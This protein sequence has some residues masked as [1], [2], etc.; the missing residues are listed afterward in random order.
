MNQSKSSSPEIE[1]KSKS[2]SS[3]SSPQ[4]NENI[5]SSPINDEI[6]W[7]IISKY[8]DDNPKALVRHH[9]ESYNDFFQTGIFQIFKEKNPIVIN[10]VFDK[11]RNDFK[12]ECKMYFGGKDG[13]KIY[14]GKPVIYD[15]ENPHY[16]YPNEARL[17]NMTYS[18]TIHYD[19]DIEYIDYLEPGEQPYIIGGDECNQLYEG[20]DEECHKKVEDEVLKGGAPTN[21][22]EKGKAIRKKRLKSVEVDMS[23]SEAA[24]MKEN[25]ENSMIGT[26]I[27]KRTQ[28]LEKIYLGKFPIMV[29]SNFCILDGFP[30]EMIYS[31]GECRNDPGGYFIIDGKEK[32]VIPQEKFGD[33]IMYIRKSK[34]E[35]F[36]YSAEI[37]S[38]SENVTKPIRTLSI[39]MVAPSKG[40]T[41]KNIVVNVPNVR[42]PV[43]LFI[44]FRALGVISDK[45]IIT[46]C[47]LDLEKYKDLLDLFIPSVHDAGGIM[48][49]PAALSYIATLTKYGTIS[50]AMEILSDYFLPHIGELNYTEKA[51]FLGYMVFRLL[52]VSSGIEIP[53]DRDNYKFKR[54]ELVGSLLYDLFREYYTLQQKSVHLSFEKKLYYNLDKY[55]NSL[56]E[57]INHNYHEIF[58]E[59]I[60]E[61]GVK[62]AFK[63]DWGAS[64]HTKRIGAVQ[65]LNR[66]SFN[67][68]IS[69]LRKLNLPLDS[70]VKLVEPRVLHCSQWGFIDPIDTPDGANIGL[71]KT[72]A[73]ATY[74]SRGNSREPIIKWMF[75]NIELKKIEECSPPAY[76][77]SLTKV[78]VNGYWAGSVSDPIKSVQKMLLYRRNAL[79]PIYTSI[80][81]EIKL[82]TIFIYCDAGRVCRPIFYK[83]YSLSKHGNNAN[84]GNNLPSQATANWSSSTLRSG[85]SLKFSFENKEIIKHIAKDEFTWENLITGFNERKKGVKYDPNLIYSI[86]DLYESTSEK[87]KD[88][89]NPTLLDRFLKKKAIIDYIDPSESENA[90]ICMNI[91]DLCDF[92]KKKRFT[93]SSERNVEEDPVSVACRGKSKSGLYT[94]L[95]IHESLI[96]GVMCNQI[97]FP[98]HNPPTRNA[99]SCG[100]SKQAVSMYHTNYNVRTDKTAV[101]LHYGQTPLVKSRY[102]EYINHDENPYGINAVVA[103]MCYTG[104]N[105][106]DAILINEGSLKRGLFNTTYYTTYEAHEEKNTTASGNGSNKH[107]MNI[108]NNNMVVGTKAGYDYSSLDIYG[109]IKENTPVNDKTVLIGLATE[110]PAA[111]KYIDNSKTPK[112]GQ[113]GVVDKSFMTEGEE[114]ERIAKVRL[115]EIRIPNLGDKFASRAGQKGTVGMVVPEANMPFTREGIRPDIIINPHAIPTRMTIGQLVE[116]VFGKT[117][118]L[119]GGFSDCT[120]FVN[121]GSKLNMIGKHL[122]DVGFHSSGNEIL[123]NGMTGEQ[124]ETEIFI[125]PTYYMRLKH[126]VK[127]K[128]N[129]RTLGPRTALTRQPVSGRANDGGLRIGEMERDVLISHGITEFLRESMMERGDKYYAA[130]CNNTGMFAIYNSSKDL[131]ISPM[132]DGPIKFVKGLTSSQENNFKNSGTTSSVRTEESFNIENITRFGREFSVVCIPYSLKLLIQELQTMNIQM[133]IITEDNIEQMENMSFSKNIDLLTHIKNITM[134]EVILDVKRNISLN[135][136]K[137]MKK[138]KTLKPTFVLEEDDVLPSPTSANGDSPEQNDESS[139]QFKISSDSNSKLISLNDSISYAPRSPENSH[140]PLK[141][142]ENESSFTLRPEESLKNNTP[143]GQTGGKKHKGSPHTTENKSSSMLRLSEDINTQKYQVGEDVLL[144]G[145]GDGHP[146]RVWKIKKIGDSFYTVET[147]DVRG[148]SSTSDSIRVVSPMDI[149]ALSEV[150]Y[151]KP[152]QNR[153]AEEVI[154]VSSHFSPQATL[155]GSLPFH[156]HPHHQP[157][158]MNSFPHGTFSGEQ[159]QEP[160]Y[161]PPNINVNPVIKIVNGPDNS[162][163]GLPSSTENEISNNV[164]NQGFLENTDPV[165]GYNT[166]YFKPIPVDNVREPHFSTLHTENVKC[167][168]ITEPTQSIFTDGL[169][170]IIK[171][172]GI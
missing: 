58:R 159:T 146:N 54:I 66:L 1:V 86:P 170:I 168:E 30:R 111:M 50:Y 110:E 21:P 11:K 41:F 158:S 92:S 153:L 65:D 135:H 108:E 89:T 140:F 98:E 152:I 10:S 52:S 141:A 172:M 84:E 95:E 6:I 134:N 155:N 90:L 125:G 16:M 114:G 63:G 131:F 101:V 162:S 143:D 28:T 26:N 133:R 72:L 29:Q 67:T 13:T 17:R 148:L 80:T 104:Y 39:K 18:M 56:F 19:I 7:K 83:D 32:T 43:P 160:F 154:Q 71:H 120:A 109:L 27:Q 116:C 42:N 130:V 75:D 48:T 144:R 165:N 138:N 96:F 87:T 115:R 78:I 59:R 94:H 57:L 129:F 145:M 64:S 132:L 51:H 99:F 161:Q 121:K 139:P 100:Q 164:M 33:N 157:L 156:Q 45:D 68:M 166:N 40:F 105:V 149:C 150:K 136:E 118:A 4:N 97:I 47:L 82:N 107:F 3:S 102:N 69:H 123:Y 9:L 122:T 171:K 113:I 34:D 15:N 119:Y 127:D 137:K 85:E 36:L 91:D 117:S 8:F 61:I 79:L 24:R 14:F 37:R 49:Q 62:K 103:I 142:T 147:D 35:E 44:L 20:G 124:L 73:I 31:L 12:H 2:S 70:G 22:P 151:A 53:T 93:N 167:K 77:A 88:V 81:F 38:V 128:I 76:L 25:I 112:K 106:E 46:T 163:G 74:V 60:V 169:P 23:P 5:S 55:E 126:M